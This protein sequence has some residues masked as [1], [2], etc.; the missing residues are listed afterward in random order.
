MSN[1]SN[2]PITSNEQSFYAGI[3]A[4]LAV[5]SLHDQPTIAR[6]I[7]N[8][9]NEDDFLACVWSDEA[10]EYIG[11]NNIGLKIKAKHRRRVMLPNLEK[12]VINFLQW[13]DDCAWMFDDLA[14]NEAVAEMIDDLNRAVKRKRKTVSG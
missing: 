5:L 10:Q 6:E 13:F 2:K 8:T 1:K 14:T 9:A 3:I 4:S 12:K 7:I 11:L